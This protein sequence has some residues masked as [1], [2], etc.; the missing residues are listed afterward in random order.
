MARNASEADQMLQAS[1]QHSELVAQIVPSPF[2][3]VH[4]SYLRTLIEDGYLGDFRELVVIGATDAFWDYTKPLHWR[5][6]AQ[7]SGFNTLSLGIIHETAMRWSPPTTRV[8]AQA[9]T[10]EPTRPA[11][12]GVE[13]LD[14]TVPDSLQVLTELEGGGR[15]IYHISGIDLFGPGH[16]IHLYGS[17]GTI[18]VKFNDGEQILVGRV[19]DEALKPLEIPVEQQDGW[20]V[21]AE[22]IGAIRGEEPVRLTDFESGV[23]YMQFTEAVHRSIASNAP[24]DLPLS[25]I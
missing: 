3:L 17:R 10:F 1:R 8:F 23:R 18:K 11:A 6:D 22:F 14:V 16:Q 4:E 5:Q 19:G 20:R 7:I 13:Q 24:V 2:G 12:T 25:K 15:G 9:T 21:E